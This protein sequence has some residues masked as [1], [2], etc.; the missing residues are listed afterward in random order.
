MFHYVSLSSDRKR[1]LISDCVQL[2]NVRFG[3]K[4]NDTTP[5]E[6][7]NIE[8]AM[9]KKRFRFNLRGRNSIVLRLVLEACGRVF[10]KLRD[11]RPE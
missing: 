10:S 9:L 8:A 2:G 7:V 3:G 11:S 5:R 6:V 4:K 1:I